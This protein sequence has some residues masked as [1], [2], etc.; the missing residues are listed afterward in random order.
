M[1]INENYFL[2]NYEDIIQSEG[3]IPLDYISFFP[4]IYDYLLAIMLEDKKIGDK[5]SKFR[6]SE[7]KLNGET[8]LEMN[9]RLFK[10]FVEK[11]PKHS[12]LIL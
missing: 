5:Y 7:Y 9:K 3:V 6:F 2:E 1:K 8:D 12:S 11:N 4:E 10:E